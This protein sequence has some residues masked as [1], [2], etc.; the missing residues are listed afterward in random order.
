[1]LKGMR[2]VTPSPSS[3]TSSSAWHLS[4]SIQPL[5]CDE[6]L[7]LYPGILEYIRQTD[8]ATRRSAFHATD[9][10]STVLAKHAGYIKTSISP[11]IRM[12][13]LA[14]RSKIEVFIISQNLLLLSASAPESSTRLLNFRHGKGSASCL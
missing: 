8:M 12:E 5:G 13:S 6:L 2:G 9:R 4:V 1:M 14:V 7:M 3:P 11:L 10:E